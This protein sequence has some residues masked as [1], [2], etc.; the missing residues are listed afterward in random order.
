M[1]KHLGLLTDPHGLLVKIHG[2]LIRNHAGNRPKLPLEE[3]IDLKRFTVK[4]LIYIEHST[5]K[6]ANSLRL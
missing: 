4:P 3:E 5:T 6:K 1:L 2:T